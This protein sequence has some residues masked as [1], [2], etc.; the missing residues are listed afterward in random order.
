MVFDD[1]GAREDWGWR[2]EYDLDGLVKV[3]FQYLAPQFGKTLPGLEL[4]LHYGRGVEHDDD[5]DDDDANNK[6]CWG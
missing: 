2:N 6:L 4:V 5:D 3:M 1:S